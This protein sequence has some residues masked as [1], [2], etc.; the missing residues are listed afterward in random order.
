[1]LAKLVRGD[2]RSRF[3]TIDIGSNA[4]MTIPSM[5]NWNDVL[6]IGDRVT[7]KDHYLNSLCV[8]YTGKVIRITKTMIVVKHDTGG[9]TRFKHNGDQVGYTFPYATLYIGGQIF[10]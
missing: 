2:R 6:A 10:S 3:E 4:M 8:R 1:M 7:I 9:E 5:L